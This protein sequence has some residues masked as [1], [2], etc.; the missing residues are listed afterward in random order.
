MFCSRRYAGLIASIQ[1]DFI[2]GQD[3][4]P[5]TLSK[6][7]DMI[8]NYVNPHK[9]GGVD[10]QEQGLS[11]YQDDNDEQQEQQG[12]GRGRGIP[13]RVPGRGHGGHV[14][15]GRRRRGTP[16]AQADDNGEENY[17]VEDEHEQFIGGPANADSHHSERL[18][19]VVPSTSNAN[20][21][22]RRPTSVPTTVGSAHIGQYNLSQ[23]SLNICATEKVVL[24]HH[25]LPT[26]WLLL[27]SCLTVD[28]VSNAD[29]LHDIHRVDCPA[30]VRCNA[31]RVRLDYQGYF[32]D[33]PYPVWYNP[34]GVANILSL[35]N[36]ASNYRVTMDSK[37][38]KG[39]TVHIGNGS[40]IE[41]TPS[42]NGL[43]RHELESK[44]NVPYMWTML[45]TVKD[46]AM[47]YSK[48][49]YERALIA[50][51]LQNIIMRPGTRKLQ[52]VVI[53]HLNNCPVTKADIKSADNIFGKN[54][55]SLKGKTVRQS[56]SHVTAEWTP[57]HQRF[58]VQ[59]GMLALPL[60]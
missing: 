9:Q 23:V 8:V 30:L 55:G 33:Y 49:A 3:K 43:Y 47:A 16:G 4:Y 45:S 14:P 21:S 31:G 56:A 54:L 52:D 51:K 58:F 27:D 36:V 7:Y 48:R 59:Q 17:H 11:F 35:N 6:A 25:T 57:S 46:R 42:H 39:I 32:G 29:L 20:A 28:I 5:K 1:N 12:R 2:S 37:R 24:K 13:G 18:Y 44:D 53:E 34:N 10:L 38:K 15:G 60:T 22:H 41:F 40:I 19:P 50:R 26:N